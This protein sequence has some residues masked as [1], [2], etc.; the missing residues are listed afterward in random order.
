MWSGWHCLRQSS[1]QRK[2]GLKGVAKITDIGFIT[3]GI[4]SVTDLILLSFDSMKGNN[5]DDEMMGMST[6]TSTPS[7]NMMIS[8]DISSSSS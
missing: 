6:D 4:L 3:L 1:L 7:D 5:E 2:Y 8:R